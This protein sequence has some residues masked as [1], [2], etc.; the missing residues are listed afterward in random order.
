[1]ALKIKGLG[2]LFENS[3]ED[4][5]VL[6]F[7]GNRTI[8]SEN[9][10]ALIEI[11]QTDTS[12]YAYTGGGFVSRREITIT[13]KSTNNCI[14][15]IKLE[16]DA[17]SDDGNSVSIRLSTNLEGSIKG[18][19]ASTSSTS[20]TGLLSKLVFDNNFYVTQNSYTL[21]V[22]AYHTTGGTI[23]IKNLKFTVCYLDN[24]ITTI[25]G[26]KWSDWVSS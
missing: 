24:T 1:M 9:I 4:N 11:S 8:P 23:T 6:I 2:D 19:T 20:F 15:W 7:K 17:K 12:E 16:L 5:Q 22:E 13:P 25:A 21:Q 18:S 14:L 3:P 10:S 26:D